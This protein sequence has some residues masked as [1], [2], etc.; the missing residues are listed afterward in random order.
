MEVYSPKLWP[1]TAVGFG[2]SLFQLA[3]GPVAGQAGSH[4]SGLGVDG[5]VQVLFRSFEDHPGQMYAQHLI[6]FVEDV[7]GSPG[8]TV[9]LPTH[10]HILGTLAGKHIC[11]VGAFEAVGI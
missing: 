3:Q 8:G 11:Q 9:N 4:D 1:A 2:R 6:D 7:S 5:L 10:A